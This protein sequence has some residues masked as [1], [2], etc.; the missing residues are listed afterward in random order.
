[1]NVREEDILDIG[2][3][4]AFKE[5]YNRAWNHNYERPIVKESFTKRRSAHWF[6][7]SLQTYNKVKLNGHSCIIFIPWQWCPISL[8]DAW[9]AQ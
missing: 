3:E 6:T 9:G 7:Q 5:M 2:C 8:K 4:Q 1:M